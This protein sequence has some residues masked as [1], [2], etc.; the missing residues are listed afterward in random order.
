[1]SIEIWSRKEIPERNVLAGEWGTKDFSCRLWTDPPDRQWLN[2]SHETEELV[3]VV[4]GKIRLEV[5]DDAV[6]LKPGDEAL[7]PAGA[8]HSVYNVGGTEAQWY[9]GYRR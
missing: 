5:G 4:E 2:F 9:Y 6:E 1:M 3:L 7:I 8:T